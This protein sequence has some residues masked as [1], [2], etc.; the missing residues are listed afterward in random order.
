MVKKFKENKDFMATLWKEV[1]KIDWRNINNEALKAF[2]VVIIGDERTFEK[3]RD[4]LETTTYDFMNRKH[5]R[6]IPLSSDAETLMIEVLIEDE[7]ECASIIKNADIIIVDQQYYTQLTNAYSQVYIFSTDK[8][9]AI[10]E[11]IL[12]EKPHLK[13]ALCYHFPAFRS[14]VAR[15]T[16]IQVSKQ[17]AAWAAGTSIPNIAPG[18]HLLLYAPLESA[19]DFSVMTLNELRM[20]FIL[21]SISG[22]KVNP[23]RL[24]PEILIMLGGA[25]GAQI[26]A[27]QLLGKI[28]A[29][30]GTLL[31]AGVAFAFTYGIGEA[32][33]LNMNYGIT[34]NK[35]DLMQRIEDLKGYGQEM[36]KTTVGN[37]RKSKE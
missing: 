4:S 17:N 5:K 32:V 30:A 19:S 16:M 28:P 23:F 22:R 1:Q 34:F 20:T 27:T 24:V 11:R 31:K 26:F 3:V 12:T 36:V 37:M 35:T 9:S 10:L 7:I 6:K 2:L 13:Q 29:G 21:A 8:E 18:P 15:E 14:T 25:K 33:F